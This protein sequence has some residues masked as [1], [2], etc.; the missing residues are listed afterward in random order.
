MIQLLCIKT[1]RNSSVSEHRTCPLSDTLSL[2]PFCDTLPGPSLSLCVCA[3]ACA[4]MW[5]IHLGV[6]LYHD[7]MLR[8][9]EWRLLPPVLRKLGRG[10][11]PGVE[12]G[13]QSWGNARGA[14]RRG[15]VI[16][17]LAGVHERRAQ[18]RQRAARAGTPAALMASSRPRS[19]GIEATPVC[20]VSK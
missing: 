12:S 2:V 17:I 10:G 6:Y 8:L 15:P 4:C 19:R 16:V 11:D 9:G 13:D 14:R 3:R 5:A 7:C 18:S 1:P 20:P